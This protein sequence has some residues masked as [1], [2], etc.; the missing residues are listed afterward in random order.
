MGSN[1][2][3]ILRIY[4]RTH[5]RMDCPDPVFDLTQERTDRDDN[6][7]GRVLEE[8]RNESLHK[9]I[10]QNFPEIRATETEL[11]KLRSQSII[12]SSTERK[13]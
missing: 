12:P 4:G 5:E 11:Q 6:D 1:K 9:I 8:F 10:R 3:K 2:L 13:K 7:G